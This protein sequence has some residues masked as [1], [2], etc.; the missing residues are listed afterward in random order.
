MANSNAER[1]LVKDL[2]KIQEDTV[3]DTIFA[4][5]D[6][7]TMMHWTAIIMGPSETDWEGAALK[8]DL[9]FPDTYPN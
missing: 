6:E 7:K 5:P 8:L 3:S 2:K 9:K 4:I 1:R